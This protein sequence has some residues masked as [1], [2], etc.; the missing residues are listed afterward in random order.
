MPIFYGASVTLGALT[1]LHVLGRSGAI[2]FGML[3]SAWCLL[4]K[5]VL[6]GLIGFVLSKVTPRFA[7]ISGFVLFDIVSLV[8]AATIDTNLLWSASAIVAFSDILYAA[9]FRHDESAESST[10]VDAPPN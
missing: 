8:A 1:S 9:M 7:L 3:A 4:A 10:S 2:A 6:A 5:P